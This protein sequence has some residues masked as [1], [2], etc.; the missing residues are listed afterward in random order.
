MVENVGEDLLLYLVLSA[1]ID[2]YLSF[3]YRTIW[4]KILVMGQRAFN[5]EL[6][7]IG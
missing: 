2:R 4:S 1:R 7:S 5:G 6:L 3:S